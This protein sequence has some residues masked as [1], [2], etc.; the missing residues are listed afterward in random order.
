MKVKS[1]SDKV[2]ASASK[3]STAGASKP[4][5]ISKT[6]SVSTTKLYKPKKLNMISSGQAGGSSL[7]NNIRQNSIG[8]S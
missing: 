6:P 5:K 2:R 4:P 1:L 3:I 7:I 8:A